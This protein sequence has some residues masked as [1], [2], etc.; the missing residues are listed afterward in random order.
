[1]A[2]RKLSEFSEGARGNDARAGAGFLSYR[3][4]SFGNVNELRPGEREPLPTITTS[5]L[6]LRS[7]E[8]MRRV[9][10]GERLIVC[11]HRVPLATLQPLDGY[12]F[13]P[14]SGTVHDVFGWPFGA[15][16]DHAR[17]LPRPHCELLVDGYR[18]WRLWPG[19]VTHRADWGEGMR[20]RGEMR[21]TGLVRKTERGNELTGRGL[22]LREE[23]L[24][25]DGR[26]V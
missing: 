14:F 13:Q 18:Q 1:M 15:A 7:K 16:P 2:F 24:R 21:G 26:E 10:L 8:V 19:R 9:T 20:A 22:A 23:L 4:G 5:D 6:N 12:V 11:R 17:R 25:M 3:L